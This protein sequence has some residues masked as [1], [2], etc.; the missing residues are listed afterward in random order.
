MARTFAWICGLPGSGNRLLERLFQAADAE[1]SVL[2][3][4]HGTKPLLDLLDA[5]LADR[6]LAV[7][8][9]RDWHA[10]MASRRGGYSM[11][12]HADALA[13]VMRVLVERHVPTQMISYE[14]LFLYP[15]ESKNLLLEWAGLPLV[16]WPDGDC[17]RDENE[18][19]KTGLTANAKA[20]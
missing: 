11:D 4:S 9:V 2:H 17:P 6:C 16:P 12:Q 19:W 8:P 1:S 10:E 13:N 15:E 7:I 5:H 20:V 18:K 14:S 3:G